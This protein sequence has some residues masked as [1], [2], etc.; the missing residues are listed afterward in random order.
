MAAAFSDSLM[1][2]G[3]NGSI[4]PDIP[5]TT[6]VMTMKFLNIGIYK[7]VWNQK[8]FFVVTGLFCKL[9]NKILKIQM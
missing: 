9:Q 4:P 7:E 1:T 2:S 3:G 8:I 5:G 6:K